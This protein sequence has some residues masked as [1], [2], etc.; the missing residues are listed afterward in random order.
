MPAGWA[1]HRMVASRRRSTRASKYE[2]LIPRR[3][4]LKLERKLAL[5]RVEMIRRSKQK[6]GRRIRKMKWRV[7]K[8]QPPWLQRH[9]AARSR[10]RSSRSRSSSKH[11]QHPAARSRSNLLSIRCC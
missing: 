10:S 2:S 7:R 4:E 5:G 8:I 11:H 9:P 6:E 3:I 1:F